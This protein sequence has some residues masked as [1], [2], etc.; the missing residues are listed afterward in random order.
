MKH[1]LQASAALAGVVLAALSLQAGTTGFILPS[2]RGDANTEFGLWDSPYNFTVAYSATLSDPGNVVNGDGALDPNGDGS[3]DAVIRQ[4][5]SNGF[6][7]GSG[8]LYN[9]VTGSVLVL[10]DVSSPPVQTVVFQTRT[11]GSELD[12]ASVRLGYDLGGGTQYL[13]ATR[14]E[15]DRT[16]GMG[17]NV[18]S[19]WEFDLTGLGVSD[20]QIEF[21]GSAAHM[22]LDSVALDVQFTAV[23]EPEEYA[24]L[25][26]A[27][28]AGFAGWRRFRRSASN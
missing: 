11:L 26:A 28:L 22:S 23:S 21:N 15:N 6:L 24:A 18:S 25:A 19:S 7:T 2:F 9:A 27:A 20:Y 12:Y 13:T 1:S 17:V 14:Q 10:S 5:D 4:L 16:T 3:S 8:N